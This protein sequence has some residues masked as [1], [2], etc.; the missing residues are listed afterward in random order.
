MTAEQVTQL[1][2]DIN[3]AIDAVTDERGVSVETIT[4]VLAET[5]AG[6][7]TPISELKDP[8]AL[9]RYLGNFLEEITR[10]VNRNRANPELSGVFH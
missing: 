3:K 4:D 7:L 6:L 1:F 5:M 2:N 9:K 8:E 10:R